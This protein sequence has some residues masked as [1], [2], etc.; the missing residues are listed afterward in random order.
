VAFLPKATRLLN[1]VK[2]KVQ[3]RKG[4]EGRE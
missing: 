3:S 2:G 4:Y 1:E